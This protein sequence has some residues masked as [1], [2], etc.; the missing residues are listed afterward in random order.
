MNLQA[1]ADWIASLDPEQRSML[2]ATIRDGVGHQQTVRRRNGAPYDPDV[3]NAV[4]AE[5]TRPSGARMRASTGQNGSRWGNL[6]EVLRNSTRVDGPTASTLRRWAGSG[7]IRAHKAGRD[8][9]VDLDD[10]ERELR[11]ATR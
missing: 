2:A 10:L 5:L 3:P 6:T 9:L 4:L 7:R 1:L 8:W 11:K